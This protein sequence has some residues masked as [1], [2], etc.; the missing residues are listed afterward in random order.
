ML[1]DFLV[2]AV[3]GIQQRHI[4]TLN[5]FLQEPWWW[6]NP[7]RLLWGNL[8]GWSMWRTNKAWPSVVTFGLPK[9]NPKLSCCLCMDIQC[10]HHLNSWSYRCCYCCCSPI[11][12]FNIGVKDFLLWITL[13]LAS[14]D[15]SFTDLVDLAKFG[16]F[17]Y[18]PVDSMRTRHLALLRKLLE[19]ELCRFW[20]IWIKLKLPLIL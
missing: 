5:W 12:D 2:R 8:A 13:A 3:H 1:E 10:M 19:V 16:D 18:S 14:D 9:E 7:M 6:K 17:S 11:K 4:S 15:C 20:I